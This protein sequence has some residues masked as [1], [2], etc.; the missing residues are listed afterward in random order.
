MLKYKIPQV[1]TLT[2]NCVILRLLGVVLDKKKSPKA[3][4]FRTF[5]YFAS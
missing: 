3:L 4:Y 2:P 1:F 5:L